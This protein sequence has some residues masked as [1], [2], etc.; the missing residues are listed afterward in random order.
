MSDGSEYIP[1]EDMLIAVHVEQ[2]GKER[3]GI[4]PSAADV[5]EM[6][7]QIL[8]G[9]GVFVAHKPESKKCRVWL[10][11]WPEAKRIVPVYYHKRRIK[12]VLPSYSVEH[13]IQAIRERIPVPSHPHDR[14]G[15][16]R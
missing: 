13:L 12:T 14:E 7:R 4:V 16:E 1:P 15:A 11:W 2:R 6:E 5:A 10:V 3:Y 9:R 8:E